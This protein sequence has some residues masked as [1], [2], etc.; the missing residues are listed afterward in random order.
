MA[1]IRTIKP[2]FPHS[3]SIGRLSR[4]ARLTFIQIW[5][6]VD[7][8]GRAR[9][10]SRM[11]ASLL[12][13]Y[14][15]DAP[16]L[17]DRWLDELDE[18]GFIVR[19][20]TDGS[21]Y[22]EVVNWEKHQRIDKPSASKFPP[23]TQNSKIPR[24]ASRRVRDGSGPRT[25]IK[26]ED[27]TSS[28][29][30]EGAAGAVPAGPAEDDPERR[31]F[32][33]GKALLGPKAGGQ[34]AKLLK[35]HHGDVAAAQVRVDRAAAAQKPA[36]FIAGCIR[37]ASTGPPGSAQPMTRSQAT[38]AE[39][40]AALQEIQDRAQPINRNLDLPAELASGRS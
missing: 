25:R 28:L 36:E 40:R 22:L 21:R 1:R 31:L 29:R 4:D 37:T 6:I 10:A 33:S 18:G 19:Y 7:D 24:E 8:E 39:A 30:S 38:R 27:Q 20:E 34:I 9:A 26:E 2:E 5:T 15:D 32:A 13:P 14:D 3:E 35:A 23:P 17:I 16:G 11:L 12:F